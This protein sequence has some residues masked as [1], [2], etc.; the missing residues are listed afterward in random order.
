MS[1]ESNKALVRE[2]YERLTNRK[3]LTAADEQLAPDFVD[4]DALP[5]LPGGPEGVKAWMRLLH[6]AFPDLSVEIEDLVAEGDRVAVRATW[7]GT[8]QGP[9]MGQ[10][11]TGRSVQFGGMVFWRIAEGRIAERW[12]YLDRAALQK[13]IAG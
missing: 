1:V 6:G 13:Q 4:H 11:A 2:H 8:H 10:A 12:A 7:R 5:G 3:D 9:F